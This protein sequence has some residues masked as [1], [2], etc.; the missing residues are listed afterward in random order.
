M[1]VENTKSSSYSPQCGRPDM[2]P[3]TAAATPITLS[4]TGFNAKQEEAELLWFLQAISPFLAMI[5]S[6]SGPWDIRQGF[7]DFPN[8]CF[9]DK[10]KGLGDLGWKESI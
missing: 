7:A 4:Q 5:L 9:T 2:S 1:R 10:S 6:L 8:E 3:T